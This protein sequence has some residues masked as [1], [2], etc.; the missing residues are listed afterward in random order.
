MPIRIH[1]S[2]RQ[3]LLFWVGFYIFRAPACDRLR[4]AADLSANA[5]LISSNQGY[6]HASISATV[7]YK[8]SQRVPA[9]NPGTVANVSWSLAWRYCHQP[10]LLNEMR[11][12]VA[13]STKA[14][15]FRT[16]R[17]LARQRQLSNNLTMQH[18]VQLCRYRQR[19]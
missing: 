5:T 1:K 17:Q 19:M 18:S 6:V 2:S 10:H 15:S 11:G 3:Q 4:T 8:A 16:I 13:E 12:V 9:R 14:P 7:L